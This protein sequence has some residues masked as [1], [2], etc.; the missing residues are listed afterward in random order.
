[1]ILYRTPGRSFTRPPRTSTMEC[2]CRLCPTP[3]MYAVTSIWL[4]SRTRATLRSAEFGFLGVVVYTRVHTP[5]RWGLPLS[6]GVLVL[7]TLSSRPLR[8]SC[9][10]VGTDSPCSLVLSLRRSCLLRGGAGSCSVLP[11]ARG[12]GR[13][14][15]SGVSLLV[16]RTG[17]RF[18]RYGEV[19]RSGTR[20]A[21]PRADRR[22]LARGT[23]RGTP[24][25]KNEATWAVLGASKR[26]PC[27][28]PPVQTRCG[29]APG[30]GM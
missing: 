26:R 12:L 9:W 22:H 7:P 8:T 17:P 29:R 30:D 14:P 13:P 18:C 1:M 15:R 6:A 11:A 3:G 23:A 4:V 28:S 27:G 20:P 25:T 2:S 21:R 16:L 10:I 24:G 5:R 19:G